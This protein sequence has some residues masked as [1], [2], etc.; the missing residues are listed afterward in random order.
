MP[1]VWEPP[2]SRGTPAYPMENAVTL[3]SL[4]TAGMA[5]AT[6]SP[7]MVDSAD[8][9]AFQVVPYSRGVPARWVKLAAKTSAAVSAATPRAA[10]AS[11]LDTGSAARPAPRCRAS[12]TPTTPDTGRS[13]AVTRAT[14]DRRPAAGTGARPV[15]RL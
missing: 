6:L 14:P 13:P 8:T 11:V 7:L 15:G 5:S 4:V 3:G 12:R 1:P 10:P 2:I 9:D